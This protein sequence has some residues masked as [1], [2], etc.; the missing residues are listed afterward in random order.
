M[1]IRSWQSIA[2]KKLMNP[3]PS[4]VNQGSNKG[5][6][7]LLDFQVVKRPHIQY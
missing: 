1:E 5:D 6:I 7:G 3:Q 2:H 4:T